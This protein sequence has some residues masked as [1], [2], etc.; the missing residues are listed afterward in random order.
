MDEKTDT[1]GQG[2]GLTVSFLSAG[3]PDSWSSVR[4][5]WCWSREEVGQDPARVL[6]AD[7]GVRGRIC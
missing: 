2:T 6:H 3:S 4:L 1:K 7:G 5:S